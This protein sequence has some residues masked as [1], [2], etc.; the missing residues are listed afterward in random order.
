MRSYTASVTIHLT[1]FAARDIEHADEI[2]SGY[3]DL[4]AN[5][6]AD[7]CRIDGQEITWPSVDW[8]YEHVGGE[9]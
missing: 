5:A 9:G 1:P 2:V 7:Q 4:I 6:Q 3:V 8:H